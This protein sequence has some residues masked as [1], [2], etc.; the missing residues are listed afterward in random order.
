M[1]SAVL[2]ESQIYVTM[3]STKRMNSLLSASVVS[4]M[5]TAAFAPCLRGTFVFDDIPALVENEIV[6]SEEVNLS[7]A[8]LHDFWGEPATSDKSHGSYRPLTTLLFREH[9]HTLYVLRSMLTLSTNDA[10]K[11]RK[12]QFIFPVLQIHFKVGFS[13]NILY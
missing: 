8:F 1:K 10:G 3:I 12:I 13:I 2:T 11:I 6:N 4:V 9:L 5:A 7:S